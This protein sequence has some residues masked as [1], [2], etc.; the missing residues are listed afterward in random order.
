ML[1]NLLEWDA[2]VLALATLG[3]ALQVRW[4]TAG[5]KLQRQAQTLR[6]TQSHE[7]SAVADLFEAVEFLRGARRAAPLEVEMAL[8]LAPELRQRVTQTLLAPYGESIG[9]SAAV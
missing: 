8:L 2:A 3:A 9:D 1:L 4:P 7:I 6:R 5:V